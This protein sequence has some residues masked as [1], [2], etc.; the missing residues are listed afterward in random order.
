MRISGAEQ[1]SRTKISLKERRRL[2]LAIE[3]MSDGRMPGD[4]A[5]CSAI[6]LTKEKVCMPVCISNCF[7]CMY[8]DTRPN[9]HSQFE[10]ES[11]DDTL[12]S[13]KNRNSNK[14]PRCAPIG[15]PKSQTTNHHS[16]RRA[17]PKVIIDVYN[18]LKQ[19]WKSGRKVKKMY[20]TPYCV[21]HVIDPGA[22]DKI[23]IPCPKCG[24]DVITKPRGGWIKTPRIAHGI[25]FTEYFVG[26][27]YECERCK[28]KNQQI[29]VTLTRNML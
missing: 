17:I 4:K 9:T 16:Q 29:Q 5:S 21:I 2:A 10:K 1:V 12:E 7:V 24:F 18:N 11:L 25:T 8:D 14:V 19:Q 15:R 13:I 22:T 3:A 27:R 6:D 20:S 26:R 28:Q 23:P